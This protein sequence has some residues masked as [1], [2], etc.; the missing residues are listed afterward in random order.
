MYK[1][2]LHPMF[3]KFAANWKM[4]NDGIAQALPC[5]DPHNPGSDELTWEEV[6]AGP[7]RHEDP[8]VQIRLF[9]EGWIGLYERQT[10]TPARI[11]ADDDVMYRH[12]VQA[13]RD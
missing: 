12:H 6:V 2:T 4:Y 5:K 11:I 8:Q 3:G 10:W 13:H 1:G 7:V 9:R